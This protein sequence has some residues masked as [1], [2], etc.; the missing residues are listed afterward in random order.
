MNSLS[1]QF[2]WCEFVLAGLLVIVLTASMTNASIIVSQ[3]LHTPDVTPPMLD[4]S[5]AESVRPV[6]PYDESP[7][8]IWWDGIQWDDQRLMLLITQTV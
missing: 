5:P 7:P 1:T 8:P 3:G 4:V 2:R 6:V